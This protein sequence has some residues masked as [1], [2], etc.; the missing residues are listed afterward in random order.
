MA[1]T[2]YTALDE[3]LGPWVWGPLLS[4]WVWYPLANLS[5]TGYLWSMCSGVY[6]L[7]ITT[8]L[9]FGYYEEGDDDGAPPTRRRL[10]YNSAGYGDNNSLGVA[11]WCF[12]Y[13]LNVRTFRTLEP[14]PTSFTFVLTLSFTSPPTSASTLSP[15]FTQLVILCTMAMMHSVLVERPAMRLRHVWK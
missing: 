3:D 5:Y 8:W 9:G 15:T 12:A 2:I 10:D 1:V 11:G 6:T 4:H 14:T 7:Y 13:L